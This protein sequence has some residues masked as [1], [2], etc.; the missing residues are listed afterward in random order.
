MLKEIALRIESQVRASDVAA[1][2][3]GEEFIILLPNTVTSSAELLAE[4]I[5][6]E[7]AS[8]PIEI[9]N[10]KNAHVTVSIGIAC[11]SPRPDDD[12]LKN[13]GESLIARADVALYRAKSAGRDQIAVSSEE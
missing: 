10:E 8:M 7:I 3:G 12:D 4:R 9:D 6:T 11:T 5:R 1:R 13:T 2:Y